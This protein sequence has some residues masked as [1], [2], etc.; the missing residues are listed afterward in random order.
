RGISG[1]VTDASGA[2]IAG[3]SVK[4]DSPATGLARAGT[5]ADSSYSSFQTQLRHSLRKG[6]S[7]TFNYTLG[8]AID[9]TSDIRNTLPTNSYNL[10]NE[11]GNSTFD[12]RHIVTSFVSY[13]LPGSHFAP[14]LTHGS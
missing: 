10:R 7:G 8:H 5:M 13:Q 3:A 6:L 12:I 4:L 2:A 11:R 9:N 1:V 14:R